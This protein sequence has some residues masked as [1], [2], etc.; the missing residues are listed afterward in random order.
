VTGSPIAENPNAR[1]ES[2]R[3]SKV[4]VFLDN[5]WTYAVASIVLRPDRE[6]DRFDGIDIRDVAE[7]CAELGEW[8]GRS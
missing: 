6:G 2:A 3:A 1:I 7:K 8:T 5:A 4:N